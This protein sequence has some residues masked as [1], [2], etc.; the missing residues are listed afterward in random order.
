MSD[1]DIPGKTAYAYVD[2]DIIAKM[3]DIEDS[4]L[5]AITVHCAHC[6]ELIASHVHNIEESFDPETDGHRDRKEV[7]A[8]Q[9]K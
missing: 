6:G 7:E 4:P 9:C 3:V 5:F 2:K 8:H 1:V